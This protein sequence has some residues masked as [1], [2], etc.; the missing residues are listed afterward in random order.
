MNEMNEMNDYNSRS[1][2]LLVRLRIH[3]NDRRLMVDDMYY[4]LIHGTMGIPI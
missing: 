2:M 3:T 4:T 1:L